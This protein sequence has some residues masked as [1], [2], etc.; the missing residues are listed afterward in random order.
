MRKKT[1]LFI[2]LIM[3]ILIAV[4]YISHVNKKNHYIETQKSRIDLY[5]KYNLKKYTSMKITKVEK[6][7]MGDYFIDGYVNGKKDYDFKAS[8]YIDDNNQYTGNISYNPKTLGKMFKQKDPKD[9]WTPDEIIKKEHLDK[10]KYEEDP[11]AFFWF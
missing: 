7:P 5:F 6:N 10:S 8:I 1:L 9:S 11:P 2:I 3:T 4:G